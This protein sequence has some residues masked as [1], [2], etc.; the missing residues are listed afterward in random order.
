VRGILRGMAELPHTRD[1]PTSAEGYE[2]ARVDEAFAE[3]ADR[4]REL[5]TVAAELRAE[6]KTLRAERAA[7]PR[8][9]PEVWPQAEF[10]PSPD[11]IAAVPAPIP[12]A[13]RVPR[14]LL[15]A[16]FLLLVGL[17][18]G[19]ADLGA[20]RIVLVMAAAWVLVALAE[21]AA[22]VKRARW[23]LDEIA[24]AREVAGGG[25]EST[26]P[27]D[28]PIVEATVVDES[29]SESNTVVT[30]LPGDEPEATDAPADAQPRR[31]RWRRRRSPA[32]SGAVDPTEV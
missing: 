16:G 7:A 26:G 15:E 12:H 27:W 22:A 20:T 2:R 31:S 29:E 9:E 17:L 3:F 24:P 4:V 11:W 1:L 14:I 5:E 32:D 6:L 18:A 10:A 19:L 28:M 13:F 25:G 8:F 30:K 23:H 21:W